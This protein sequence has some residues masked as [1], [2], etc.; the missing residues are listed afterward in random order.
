MAVTT[1]D[2]WLFLTTVLFPMAESVG[3]R[4]GAGVEGSEG[5]PPAPPVW[6]LAGPEAPDDLIHFEVLKVKQVEEQ[7]RVPETYPNDWQVL[8]FSWL[9]SQTSVIPSS[10]GCWIMLSPQ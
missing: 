9:V 10:F 7:E 6:L 2:I 3:A 8:L 4:L 5:P 1:K